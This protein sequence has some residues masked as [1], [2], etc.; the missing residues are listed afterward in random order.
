MCRPHL[1][2]FHCFHFC[3]KT[4]LVHLFSLF[5]FVINLFPS[6]S[7]YSTGRRGRKGGCWNGKYTL[8]FHLSLRNSLERNISSRH[9]F[10]LLIIQI[11]TELSST[12][13]F[14]SLIYYARE[15]NRANELEQ[16][17]KHVSGKSSI[18]WYC[19]VDCNSEYVAHPW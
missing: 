1:A 13:S 6:L 2:G 11:P 16:Q 14:S 19:M 7:F 12:F 17:T 5:S 8:L 4:L 18:S 10:Y 15:Y 3:M 9:T